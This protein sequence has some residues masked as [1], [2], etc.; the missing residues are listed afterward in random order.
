MSIIVGRAGIAKLRSRFPKAQLSR[1]QGLRSAVQRVIAYIAAP[2]GRFPLEL[3]LR[4]TAFQQ[5]VWR[6]VQKIAIGRTATYSRIA[7]AIGAP[8]AIRAVAGSCARCWWS[9][10]IPCH[11]V[12]HKGGAS[13]ATA[14]SEGRRRVRWVAYEAGL[15]AKRRRI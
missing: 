9:F 5:R 12:L 4:G 2:F 6:E 1:D 3:D 13:A 7:Q 11:R 14:D 15:I 10:A 8:K